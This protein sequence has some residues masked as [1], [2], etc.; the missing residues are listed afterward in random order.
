[1][2]D[3]PDLTIESV[4]KRSWGLVRTRWGSI[5]AFI[6]L[7]MVVTFLNEKFTEMVTS[8]VQDFLSGPF[9]LFDVFG[10]AA[11]VELIT[12]LAVST[13]IYPI[14]AIPLGF[15]TVGT[16]KVTLDIVRG[17]PFS[18]SRLLQHSLMEWAFTVAALVMVYFLT[19]LGILFLIIPG[20]IFSILTTLTVYV[21]VDQEADPVTAMFESIRLMRGNIGFMMMVYFSSSVAMFFGVLACLVGIIPVL[22]MVV[23]LNA[24]IYDTLVAQRGRLDESAGNAPI[25]FTEE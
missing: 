2:S 13:M 10:V 7:L 15:A 18:W 21:V 11:V 20:V 1:M 9:G 24:I 23:M 4:W 14:T 16:T 6:V 17:K 19:L 5:L 3:V 12:S 22:L 8:P 25:L